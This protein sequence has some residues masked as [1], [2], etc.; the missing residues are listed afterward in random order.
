M[1][2]TLDRLRREHRRLDRLIDNCRNALRQDEMKAIKRRRLRLRDRIAMLQGRM[3][4]S[5]A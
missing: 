2:T 4:Q 1:N 5:P 3:N